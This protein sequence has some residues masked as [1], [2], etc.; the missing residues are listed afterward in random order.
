MKPPRAAP[1]L[2]TDRYCVLCKH[3]QVG[4]ADAFCRHREV[5]N[6]VTGNLENIYCKI[7]RE[8]GE[9]GRSGKN[10]EAAK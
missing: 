4:V 8:Y 2:N 1:T 7:E 10:Y 3:F 9:C 5:R 6:L